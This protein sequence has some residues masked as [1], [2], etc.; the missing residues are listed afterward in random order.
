[1][2]PALADSQDSAARTPEH[3]TA[4]SLS[5]A[6]RGASVSPEVLRVVLAD[7]H[8]IVRDGLNC[9]L[10]GAPDITVVGQAA[11]GAE[12]IALVR[13]LNPDVLVL[14]V[15]MP[16]GDG[17]AVM[18]EL[19]ACCPGTG[20]LILTMLDDDELAIRMI[21]AGAR[22]FLTKNTGARELIDAIRAVAR[23]ETVVR[24][25]APSLGAPMPR[26]PGEGEAGAAKNS[27]RLLSGRE[28]SVLRMVAEG[29]SGVEIAEHLG[30]STK[31][32]DA[33]KHRVQEK[34]RIAHRTD[35]VKFAVAAGLLGG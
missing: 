24:P 3:A 6:H 21:E 11:D 19:Q 33:Y 12:A 22:G 2:T 29:F 31:T 27:Y 30:I 34:L 4:G 17:D 20:I 35:Y 8:T 32:V 28:Q 10:R 15:S 23:G 9:V 18:G 26:T 7:D 25:S 13:E 16:R 5:P 1:M 14:D